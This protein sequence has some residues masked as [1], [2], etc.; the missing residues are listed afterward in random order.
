MNYTD[1]DRKIA[2]TSID[3]KAL[4]FGI[5]AIL[6]GIGLGV[7]SYFSI[8]S[9]NEKDKLYKEIEAVV[10]DYNY[11]YDDENNTELRAIIVEYLVDGRTYRKESTS[12]SSIVRSI[13]DKVYVKYNPNNPSDAIWK[14]DSSNIFIPIV[15]GLFVVVGIFIVIKYIKQNN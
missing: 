13:G 7:Y 4:I 12:Y 15:G 3:K 2:D 8:K 1:T 11:Q 10:V 14:N 9:Y 5:I 6:I